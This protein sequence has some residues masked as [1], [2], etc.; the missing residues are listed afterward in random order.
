M[1][2]VTSTQLQRGSGHVIVDIQHGPLSLKHYGEEVGV[3]MSRKHFQEIL[4]ALG[5]KYWGEKAL[6]AEEEGYLGEKESET[7]LNDL[8]NAA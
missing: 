6:K 2:S 4:D 3:I 5:D 1:K 7:F 8:L